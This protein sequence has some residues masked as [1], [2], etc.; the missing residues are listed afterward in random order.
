MPAQAWELPAGSPAVRLEVQEFYTTPDIILAG[1]S[2]RAGAELLETGGMVKLDATADGKPVALREGQRLLLR[3][4][5]ARK[6][7]GMQLFQ[8]INTPSGQHGSDWQLPP[9]A[10]DAAT[11]NA[12]RSQ[13]TSSIDLATDG[14]W[15]ELAGGKN[16]LL[17]FFDKHTS[18]SAST[19]AR[20]RKRST[21][22]EEKAVLKQYSKANHKK[23]VCVTRVRIDVD[24]TGAVQSTLLPYSDPEVSNAMLAA[25]NQLP[26]WRPARFRK[27]AAPHRLEKISAVGVLSIAYT[28]AG[29]RLIGVQWDEDA[30]HMPRIERYMAPLLAQARRQG[31]QQFA[32]QFASAA[33]LSLDENL[34][35]EF[36][37]GGLGWINCDRFLEQGPRVEF[38]VQTAQPNTVVTLVF[39]KQRTI[40]ASSRTEQTAALFDKVPAGELATVVAMRREKGITYLATAA[41]TLGQSIQPNLD[42]R[43][44]SLEE[45][46][47]T[48]AKL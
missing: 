36:E 6:E 29:K 27:L 20:L 7:A 47:T 13:V 40:L 30:T 39:Q 21:S 14:R 22:P 3:M 43:P 9:A 28:S 46:R 37:A 15:P 48:L 5:T 10:A 8:G 12:I 34:Y 41:V 25:A 31:Q 38:A 4:P 35:Y 33:P 44:V 24:S 23:V 17:K 26:K 45:L 19:L 16:A 32:A 11:A 1:L 18:Y 2:T 42:F